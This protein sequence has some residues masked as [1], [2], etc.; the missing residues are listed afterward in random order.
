[1]PRDAELSSDF[2]E[3]IARLVHGKSAFGLPFGK[4]DAR[5]LLAAVTLL[6]STP[7]SVGDWKLIQETLEWRER[8]RR[9]VA[10]WNSV[11]SAFGVEP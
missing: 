2:R 7:K 1:M 11:I 8:A 9:C 5:K 4:A 3:A 10:H 6:G